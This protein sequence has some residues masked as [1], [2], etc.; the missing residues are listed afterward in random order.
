[1]DVCTE[2][3]TCNLQWG[4]GRDCQVFPSGTPEFETA[5]EM[6]FPCCGGSF[7]NSGGFDHIPGCEKRRTP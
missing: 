4:C 7:N 3:E 5:R 1:M 2:T 6:E